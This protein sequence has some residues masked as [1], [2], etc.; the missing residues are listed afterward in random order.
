MNSNT[1]DPDGKAPVATLLHLSD[2]HFAQEVTEEGRRL[3]LKRGVKSHA[4]GKIEALGHKFDDLRRCGKQVDLV[5]VTGDISTDGSKESLETALNFIEKNDIYQ[6]EPRRLVAKGLGIGHDQRIVIPGNHD[7]Y[8]GGLLPV[9][10]A[11]SAL[12]IVFKTPEQYPYA[13]GFQKE[14]PEG[15]LQLLFFVFDSTLPR[16]ASGFAWDK[17]AQGCVEK[18]EC[19]WLSQRA[20]QI[21]TTGSVQALDGQPF[22]IKRDRVIKIALLHHHPIQVKGRIAHLTKL[23]DHQRFVD[24]CFQASIDLVLFGHEHLEYHHREVRNGHQ[25][26]FLCCASASEFTSDNGFYLIDFY[27]DKSIKVE[28]YHWIPTGGFVESERVRPEEDESEKTV[29]RPGQKF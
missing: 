28:P 20:E 27:A 7:R 17:V 16:W 23:R 22:T 11:S 8:D 18:A 14:D 13:V 4:Y 15:D 21:L 1:S 3:W 9:Q 26:D 19:R 12:E 6:G 5:I 25:I 24:A 2:F 10:K 29:F